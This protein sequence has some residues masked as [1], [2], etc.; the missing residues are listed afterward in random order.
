[1][2][3]PNDLAVGAEMARRLPPSATWTHLAWPFGWR[4]AGE[5]V[6]GV[7]VVGWDDLDEVIEGDHPQQTLTYQSGVVVGEFL[8]E[9]RPFDPAADAV[10]LPGQI[11]DEGVSLP[12]GHGDER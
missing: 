8:H 7:E 9:P 3:R 5:P 11:A 6:V 2:E 12:G 10:E 4:Q 1:M